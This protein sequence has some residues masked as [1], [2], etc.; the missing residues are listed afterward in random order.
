MKRGCVVQ[1]HH[2]GGRGGGDGGHRHL[3]PHSEGGANQP[4]GSARLP[5]R[6]GPGENIVIHPLFFCA[7]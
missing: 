4:E 6:Y 5:H 2:V 7:V 1:E 3:P